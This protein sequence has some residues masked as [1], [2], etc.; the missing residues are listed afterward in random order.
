[1]V[2]YVIVPNEEDRKIIHEVIYNELCMGSALADSK[3]EYLRIIDM[4]ARQRAEAVILG[5]TE[6]G[7]LINQTDTGI[8]TI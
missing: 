7:I 3:T 6:I 4:L 2:S 8:K 5:C 1:M